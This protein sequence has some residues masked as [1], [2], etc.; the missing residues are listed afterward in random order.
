MVD[1]IMGIMPA[2]PMII[3]VLPVPIGMPITVIIAPIM[4]MITARVDMS[5][6]PAKLEL[7]EHL[8]Q[9][10]GLVEGL[11]VDVHAAKVNPVEIGPTK[12]P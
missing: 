10:V 6:S 5:M 7:R 1:L 11:A 9:G 12:Q 8:E 2:P 3:A 4:V